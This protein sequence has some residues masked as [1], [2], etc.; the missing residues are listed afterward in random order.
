[1]TSPNTTNLKKIPLTDFFGI[2]GVLKLFHLTLTEETDHR[3][4]LTE[5]H[6][7]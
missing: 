5:I 7:T 2:A 3:F 1:M 4:P 6:D